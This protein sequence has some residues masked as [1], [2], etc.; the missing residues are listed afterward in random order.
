[1]A[2]L[3]SLV[4][5]ARESATDGRD[6]G[7]SCALVDARLETL[8][9]LF[10]SYDAAAEL[11]GAAA[12]SDDATV[13]I[14]EW[15]IAGYDATAGIG[16]TAFDWLTVAEGELLA[17]VGSWSARDA[18]LALPHG[19][20]SWARHDRSRDR[21]A[22]PWLIERL[23]AALTRIVADGDGV[24]LWCATIE[25][26][27]GEARC[28][29]V[30]DVVAVRLHEAGCEPLAS[31]TR[32]FVGAGMGTRFRFLETRI[33]PGETLLAV[34]GAVAGWQWDGLEAF[35]GMQRRD[36]VRLAPFARAVGEG[37]VRAAQRGSEP[38]DND[39]RVVAIHRA[40]RS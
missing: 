2:A 15:S 8:A 33:A 31:P 40:K 10:E 37:V 30:G 19:S 39:T 18:A 3:V 1:M 34:S 6:A 4:A 36:E 23:A 13:Q 21:A 32:P 22:R 12:L 14:L 38:P 16:S 25:P 5:P 29:A 20:H 35:R 11:S 9:A 26:T 7:D 24:S 28:A 17:A 27:N